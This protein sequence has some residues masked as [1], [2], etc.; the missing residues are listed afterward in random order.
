MNS[1]ATLSKTAC[2]SLQV[3]RAMSFILETNRNEKL[4]NEEA[5]TSL[6]KRTDIACRSWIHDYGRTTKHTC[7]V[8]KFGV[9]WA[10]FSSAS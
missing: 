6:Y 7:S 9:C 4:T 10:T 8:P 2:P 1:T 5:E 3:K